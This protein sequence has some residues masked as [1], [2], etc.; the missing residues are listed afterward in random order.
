MW[1]YYTLSELESDG[2]PMGRITSGFFV[3]TQ[4]EHEETK[5]PGLGLRSIPDLPPMPDSKRT[6]P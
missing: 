5:R 1:D 6:R 3:G 4:Q 2:Q